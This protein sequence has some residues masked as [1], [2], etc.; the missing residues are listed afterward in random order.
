MYLLR[1]AAEAAART[2][3]VTAAPLSEPPPAFW[4]DTA[5]YDER[6]QRD[7][8]A[9]LRDASE[10]GAVPVTLQLA[11]LEQ[12]HWYFTVDARPRAPTLAVNA[13]LAQRFHARMAEVMQ[14]ID[15]AQVVALP[16]HAAAEVKHALLSYK[17]ITG[18][19]AVALDAVDHQQGVVRLRYW[20]HGDAPAERFLVDD[21]EVPPAYAK[22]RACRYF[23]RDLFQQRIAWLPVR[24]GAMS[25]RVELDGLPATVCVGAQ[26]YAGI[27]SA[28]TDV[29]VRN[30]ILVDAR[31]TLP[32]GKAMASKT[33]AGLP[34]WK[35]QVLKTVA[36]L[37]PVRSR[38]RNAWVFADREHDADDNAEHLYRWVR[39]THPEINAWFLLQPGTPDWHRLQQEGFRLV[40]PGLRRKLLLLNSRHIASSHPDYALGKF[41]P[42][43]YGDAM[44]WRFTYLKHGV[45]A[46]DQSHYYAAQDFDCVI[47]PSPPEVDA[48]VADGT[49]YTFTRR[50]VR[51]INLPR[52][53]RLLQLAAALPP[54]E[55]RDIVV[56]PTWRNSLVDERFEQLDRSERLLRM[57]ESDFVATWRRVLHDP[58]LRDLL[59]AHGRSL[60]FMPH[61]NLVPYLDA[62]DIP[63]HVRVADR[64]TMSL[65]QQLVRC[66][67][68]VTD[69]TSVAF[70]IAL[71]RRAV[72]YYQFDRERFYGGDHAWRPG[73]F[74]YDR[75]GFGPVA[76]THVELVTHLTQFLQQGTRP[77]DSYLAR[78][79]RALPNREPTACARVFEAMLALRRPFDS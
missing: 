31:A 47:A 57:R 19:S 11:I 21:R 13:A 78:M 30:R 49:P 55:V 40:A 44:N 62:F 54:S 15:A 45:V 63:G 74:D 24:E 9:P 33:P 75:D 51:L 37:A 20:V 10:A 3:N 73:Y 60:V 23:R 42:R 25:L 7:F 18:H 48:F 22:L 58:A 56:M 1:P 36:R 14:W 27:A 68:F 5:N 16:Q 79:Q 71:L 59:E 32:R 34:K 76:M 70:D 77:T 46:N 72:F 28:R 53:D 38:F 61:S 39:A 43:V 41:D 64:S 66:C 65:Q 8:I 2:A 26:P 50:E 4:R 6:L 29:V 17:A 52:Y 12:V 69:Y 67:A 35:A